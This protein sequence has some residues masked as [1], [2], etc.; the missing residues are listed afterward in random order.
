[1]TVK[2]GGRWRVDQFQFA[3]AEETIDGQRPTTIACNVGLITGGI[4]LPCP[5]YEWDIFYGV[6]RDGRARKD[7]YQGPQTFTGSIPE[8]YVL[9]NTRKAFEMTLGELSRA[10][11]C[12]PGICADEGTA[13]STTVTA[14]TDTGSTLTTFKACCGCDRFAVFTGISVG[15]IGSG[16]AANTVNVFSTERLC[17]CCGPSGWN[18]PQPA[19]CDVYE[20]RRICCVGTATGNKYLVGTQILPTM[21]W[22]AR[23]RNSFFHGGVDVGGNM[24]VNYLGGKVNRAT[25]SAK[26]G[27]HLM[28][29]WD[30]VIF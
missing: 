13:S 17:A 5:E 21:A 11:A 30:E 6:G 25:I 12:I 7:M 18:G 26:S 24:T 16:G 15:Y 4:D 20:I 27:E 1:M 28:L 22:A 9:F 23:Y 19:A 3:I 14:M 10:P 2:G 29:A 8:M